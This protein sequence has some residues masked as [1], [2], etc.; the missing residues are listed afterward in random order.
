MIPT[1][2]EQLLETKNCPV[3][4]TYSL[5]ELQNNDKESVNRSSWEALAQAIF[6]IIKK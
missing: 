3:F 2:S 5:N 1:P 6:E 4:I